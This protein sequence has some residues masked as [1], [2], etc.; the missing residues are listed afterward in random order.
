MVPATVR[1]TPARTAREMPTLGSYGLP[2]EFQAVTMNFPGTGSSHRHL[3]W[4]GESVYFF[5][6]GSDVSFIEQIGG[7]RTEPNC[8]VGA[9]AAFSACCDSGPAPP[10]GSIYLAA[11]RPDVGFIDFYL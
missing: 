5:E 11:V 2:L 9:M 7:A 10:G 6:G 4:L 3:L 1:M 8:N